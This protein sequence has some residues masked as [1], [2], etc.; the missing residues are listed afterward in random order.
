MTEKKMK[1]VFAPGCF[2]NLDMTQEEMDELLAEINRM[3]DSGEMLENA[4]PVSEL[5]LDELPDDVIEWIEDD[6]FS[7]KNTR[8]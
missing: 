7:P 3:V 6:A 8:H 4:V 1:I 5:D 2:D